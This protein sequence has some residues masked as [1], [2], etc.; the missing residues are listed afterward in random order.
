MRSNIYRVYFILYIVAI[1]QL[2]I[3]IVDR[4]DAEVKYKQIINSII[5]TFVMQFE[6]KVQLV[7]PIEAVQATVFFTSTPKGE[8][9]NSDPVRVTI[10]PKNLYSGMEK[11]NI[12]YRA[13]CE[14]DP[15]IKCTIATDPNATGNGIFTVRFLNEPER[16]YTFRIWCKYKRYIPEYLPE[17]VKK[18]IG[19]IIKGKG[20]N[21]EEETESE[22]IKIHIIVRHS[23]LICV[24]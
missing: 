12:Q 17:E 2:L 19:K 23:R 15:T 14:T 11:R 5:N 4:D 13:E 10:T 8:D 1:L 21:I 6:D 18:R 24:C 22:A 9:R 3:F 7:G 16:I 20:I